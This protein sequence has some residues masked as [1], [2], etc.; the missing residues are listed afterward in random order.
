MNNI[1]MTLTGWIATEP[2]ISVRAGGQRMTT[3][4]LASTAR[5]FDH[6]KDEWVDGRTHWFTI[7]VFRAA[8]TNAAASLH[9][10]DPVI[11]TGR[12]CTAEWESDTA[13]GTDTIIDATAIGHDLMRGTATFTP[14]KA[15]TETPT[16]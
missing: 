15:A 10:G 5:Y 9:K 14:T 8:A 3:F 12:Y 1:T 16:H 11:V 2:K 13:T 7:R 6:T 4:R